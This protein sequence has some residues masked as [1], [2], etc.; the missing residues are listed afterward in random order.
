MWTVMRKGHGGVDDD[1]CFDGEYKYM[2][3]KAEASKL[4]R[5]LEDSYSPLKCSLMNPWC[6]S[7]FYAWEVPD[8]YLLQ[9]EEVI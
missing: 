8:S 3:T 6:G 4:A 2:D 7:K 1:V 9:K 5:E